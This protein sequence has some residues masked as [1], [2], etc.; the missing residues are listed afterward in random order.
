[1]AR[2][3]CP[4]PTIQGFKHTWTNGHFSAYSAKFTPTIVSDEETRRRNRVAKAMVGGG[5]AGARGNRASGDRDL[6]RG[7]GGRDRRPGPR[8]LVAPAAQRQRRRHRRQ[9]T[10]RRRP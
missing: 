2:L 7:A 5:R 10:G 6:F 4:V 1:M 3:G 8:L 9:G